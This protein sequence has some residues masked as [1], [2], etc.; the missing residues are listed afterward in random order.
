MLFDHA[1][2]LI[3]IP[4]ILFLAGSIA[5][6]SIPLIVGGIGLIVVG[7]FIFASPIVT[8]QL[9]NTTTD[10][11]YDN[12]TQVNNA[13][14]YEYQLNQSIENYSYQRN[15]LPAND[16]LFFAVLLSFIGIAGLGVG[17]LTLRD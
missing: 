13:S 2:W 4:F 8:L 7:V 12:V 16:N 9:D 15:E 3:G 17:A 1:L 5:K 11:T 10:Y 6:K 14:L